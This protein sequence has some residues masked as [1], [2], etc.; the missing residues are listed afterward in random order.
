MVAG[1]RPRRRQSARYETTASPVERLIWTTAIPSAEPRF[2][3]VSTRENSGHR[4][5]NETE[6]GHGRR[7][8]GRLDEVVLNVDR[9]QS[10][11]VC[12]V[13]RVLRFQWAVYETAALPLSYVGAEANLPRLS[14]PSHPAS[15]TASWI[16][17]DEQS[18]PTTPDRLS[19]A[20]V[21]I[22]NDLVIAGSRGL[23]LTLPDRHAIAGLV[24]AR[25][26]PQ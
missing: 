12:S 25:A 19:A 15:A 2:R 8:S 3:E 11:P 6:S 7:R 16:R 18:P 24:A 17:I 20:V 21:E 14:G 4:L 10:G 26:V 23:G 1:R 13:R 22:A 9:S 5:R